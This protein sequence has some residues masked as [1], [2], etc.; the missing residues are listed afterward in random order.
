MSTRQKEILN[1]TIEVT[2]LDN[3]IAVA[4]IVGNNVIIS[5]KYQG[6]TTLNI[7]YNEISEK[8]NVS[9]REYLVD[10]VNIGEYVDIGI[11]YQNEQ[12][13]IPNDDM[14]STSELTGWR[15][16]SKEGT[17]KDGI[18]KLISAGCPLTYNH[19]FRDS[20]LS[21]SNLNN[22]NLIEITNSGKGFRK[23]G[24]DS[25]NLKE[26]FSKN[27]CIDINKG[28]HS[29]GCNTDRD[30]KEGE[31]KLNEVERLYQ[32]ITGKEEK[33]INLKDIAGENKLRN[34]CS[35]KRK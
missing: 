13:F 35:Q 3:N 7:K 11:N 31:F 17:G 12:K 30:G 21:I 10:L 2:S 32:E 23:N 15:V 25:N 20:D 22:L 6:D 24:F 8:L 9:I 29:F 18:I 4:T 26:L 27:D 1:K 34:S 5:G 33:M 16:L 19:T 28:I 14:F